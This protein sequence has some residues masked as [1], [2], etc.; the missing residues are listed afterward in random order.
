VNYYVYWS[1][2]D[3]P[4]N[5]IN[6]QTVFLIIG[7]VCIIL[8]VLIKKYHLSNDDYDKLILLWGSGFIAVFSILMFCLLQFVFLINSKNE[9]TEIINSP[10]ARKLEGVISNFSRKVENK[11]FAKVTTESFT[12]DSLAFEYSD[13]LLGQFNSFSKTN[14]GIFKDGL[15]VRITY[16]KGNS[17]Y[18]ENDN[19]ILKIEIH[20]KGYS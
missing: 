14:N 15:P 4:S 9:V 17:P 10:Q 5:S 6:S 11:R 13:V 2:Q 1:I 20:T 3:T 12:V 8:W 18:R 16:I 7:T 19:W